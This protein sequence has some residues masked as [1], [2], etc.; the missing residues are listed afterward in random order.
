MESSSLSGCCVPSTI[1]CGLYFLFLMIY[2]AGFAS[3]ISLWNQL[4]E[5]D[6]K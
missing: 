3:R 6:T 4:K 2:D 1:L 5:G